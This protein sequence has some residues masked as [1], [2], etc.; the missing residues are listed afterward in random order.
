MEMGGLSFKT[1]SN[2]IR[3]L[4]IV[5]PFL[6]KKCPLAENYHWVWDRI[7]TCSYNEF[8]GNEGGIWDFKRREWYQ[9]LGELPPNKNEIIRMKDSVK[10]I[11]NLIGTKGQLDIGE[12]IFAV[13]NIEDTAERAKQI[14]IQRGTVYKNYGWSIISAQKGEIPKDNRE[15]EPI[16]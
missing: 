8:C 2:L 14:I 12:E 15:I 5:T 11:I 6:F 1:N 7:C 10:I 3:V 4:Y 16:N 13:R 9:A